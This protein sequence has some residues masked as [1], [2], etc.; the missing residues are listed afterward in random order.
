MADLDLWLL[1]VP[2]LGI[3]HFTE[4]IGHYQQV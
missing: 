3:R 4:E 2:V 1:L